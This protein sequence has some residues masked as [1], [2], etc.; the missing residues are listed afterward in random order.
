MSMR[1]ERDGVVGDIEGSVEL[2][3]DDTDSSY[4]VYSL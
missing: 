2:L 1:V 3:L 4:P